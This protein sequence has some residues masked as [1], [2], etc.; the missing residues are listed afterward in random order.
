V[1]GE[2]QQAQARRKDSG[3]LV[4]MRRKGRTRRIFLGTFAVSSGVEV[5]GSAR[6]AE[7]E[8]V[9]RQ[10]PLGTLPRPV[11]ASTATDLDKR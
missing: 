1:V 3:E 10:I 5:I 8:M 7:E 9:L 6:V 2:G 4:P 11:L